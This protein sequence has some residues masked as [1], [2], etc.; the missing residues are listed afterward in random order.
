MIVCVLPP[1]RD[2][3]NSTSLRKLTVDVLSSRQ[4]D[5]FAAS[6]RHMT[7]VENL[8]VHLARGNV[9]TSC[10]L[11]IMKELDN[12]DVVSNLK[13]LT[14]GYPSFDS[15]KDDDPTTN[16]SLALK[17]LLLKRRNLCEAT[18]LQDWKKT[19]V[20]DLPA[21]KPYLDYNRL[22]SRVPDVETRVDQMNLQAFRVML[23]HWKGNIS[24]LLF[25]LLSKARRGD[26]MFLQ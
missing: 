13:Q 15:G 17:S 7:N 19:K 9:S 14:L 11:A 26:K 25:L 16:L 21:I 20:L 12:N 22:C 23:V 4:T 3:R 5:G 18:I 1:T 24:V 2:T 6:L 8:E 10:Y